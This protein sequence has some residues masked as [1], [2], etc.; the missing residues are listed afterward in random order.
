MTDA[1]WSML[2]FLMMLLGGYVGF[3]AGW[4][5]RGRLR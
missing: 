3:M 5:T 1:Q 2:V 4:V